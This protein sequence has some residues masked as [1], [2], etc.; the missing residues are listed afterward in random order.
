M[1]GSIAGGFTLGIIAGVLSGS[2]ALPMKFAKKWQWE[3]TWIIW[4]VWSLLIIPWTIALITVPNLGSVYQ[5]VP[6]QT[7]LVVFLFGFGWGV[8]GVTFG[9]G[10]DLVGL[11]LGNAIMMGLI[12]GLGSL[13]P[14]VIF[15][16]EALVK[17]VGL[18]IMG[19]VAVMV[20]G[21]ATC[22][23]A[24]FRKEKAL[25]GGD[26]SGAAENKASKGPFAV[27]LAVCVV[28]GILSPMLNFAFVFGDK[29][30]EG[31]VN[32]G[33]SPI[34]GPNAIWAIA[35]LG[36]LIV[37]VGYCSYRLS[38]NKTWPLFKAEGSRTHW[39]YTFLMGL[40]WMGGIALY[41]MSAANLGKLGPSLGWPVFIGTA[42]IAGNIMGLATG[43]WKGSGSQ[44]LTINVV[45]IALLL[46]GLGLVGFAS[47]L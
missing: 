38:K 47:T 1:I 6:F 24:G 45:G 4:S 30:R 32:A 42:I 44:P 26:G 41:G 5:G 18:T 20:V 23:V 29:I 37:N 8:G 11:A 33:A 36:G 40:M 22:A 35:L 25:S 19:G 17:P 39:A 46:V 7:L 12:N 10:L 21:I 28:S 34:N 43:E 16:R 2:F 9:L 27:G 14:L 15:N 31:A 13:L 3:N